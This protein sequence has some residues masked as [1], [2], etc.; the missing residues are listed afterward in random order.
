[1]HQHALRIAPVHE[2]DQ[3]VATAGTGDGIDHLD[4][5]GFNLVEAEIARIDRQIGAII[6]AVKDGM[7]HSALKAELASLEARK[8]TLEQDLAPQ[9]AAAIIH[10]NLPQLYRRKVEQLHQALLQ[11]D[12]RAEAAEVLRG[13]IEQIRLIPEGEHLAI[14]LYGTIAGIMAA[15]NKTAA[16][17]VASGGGSTVLV[18]GPDLPLAALRVAL[19]RSLRAIA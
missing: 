8:G 6:Q 10:P 7:Y 16:Q 14:E 9:P 12:T 3:P 17:R 13:L 2:G 11:P 1:M 19:A 5:G 4:A 18:A 15:A